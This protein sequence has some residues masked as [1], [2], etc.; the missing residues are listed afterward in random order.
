MYA[1]GHVTVIFARK[2]RAGTVTLTWGLCSCWRPCK[3]TL[4]PRKYGSN[5]AVRVHCIRP[6]ETCLEAFI[7]GNGTHRRNGRTVNYDSALLTRRHM[8]FRQ[9][10]SLCWKIADFRAF[11]PCGGHNNFFPLSWKIIAISCQSQA[12]S[13]YMYFMKFNNI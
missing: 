4:F 10:P 8:H 13:Q 5:M 9:I 2:W 12:E 11:G 6:I 3:R 1:D 7:V